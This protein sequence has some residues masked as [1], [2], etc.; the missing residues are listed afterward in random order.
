MKITVNER[1]KEIRQPKVG[2]VIRTTD[3][4][5]YMI[6][7]LKNGY[8]YIS[9]QKDEVGINK[10]NNYVSLEELFKCNSDDE[11]VECELIVNLR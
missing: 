9:L 2:E 6:C 4:E 10:F 5:L 1:I 7:D 11:I 8:G 3:G